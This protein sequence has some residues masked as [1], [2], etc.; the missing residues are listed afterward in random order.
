MQA[1]LHRI[2]GLGAKGCLV[3]FSSVPFSSHVRTLGGITDWDK[4]SEQ[5]K[6]MITNL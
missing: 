5:V 6:H 3:P 1:R 2:S 4:P